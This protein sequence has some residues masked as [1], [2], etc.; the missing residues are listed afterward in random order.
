MFHRRYVWLPLLTSLILCAPGC[1]GQRLAPVAGRVTYEGQPV[2]KGYIWFVPDVDKGAE[3]TEYSQSPIAPDGT[4]ELTTLGKPGVPPGWYK[5][6]VYATKND[7]P[8][9][10]WG[11]EPQWLVPVKYSM[12]TTTDLAVEVVHSPN[13]GVYDFDLKSDK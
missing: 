2:P 12:A 8:S 13:Q 3:H 1:S 7:P 11:W 6:V 9:S 5:V 10:P 4:Y